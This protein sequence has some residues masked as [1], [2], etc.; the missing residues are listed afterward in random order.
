MTDE[1][2]DK[3]AVNSLLYDFYGNL[4]TDRQKQI[5]M[6]YH[7]ENLSLAEI[8][9][10]LEISRQAVHDALKKAESV[11]VGY[12]ENLSLVQKFMKSEKT[13]S[14]IEEMITELESDLSA[15]KST[16]KINEKIKEMRKIID[17]LHE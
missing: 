9:Q 12:E 17:E 4:L 13:I 5:M 2:I 1:N 3:V 15:N 7:E 14:R 11:L 6:L 16:A 10:E 8:A